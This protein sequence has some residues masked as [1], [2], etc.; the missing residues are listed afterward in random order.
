MFTLQIC[1][2]YVQYVSRLLADSF[3]Y[4]ETHPKVSTKFCDTVLA[5]Y[6][7]VLYFISLVN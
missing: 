3:T 2:S 4:I 1:M 5:E 7:L 6:Q